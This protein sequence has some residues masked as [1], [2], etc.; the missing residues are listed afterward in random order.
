MGF[1]SRG[2]PDYTCLIFCKNSLIPRWGHVAN[3]E[4]LKMHNILKKEPKFLERLEIIQFYLYFCQLLLFFPWL[5]CWR[6]QHQQRANIR[7]SSDIHGFTWKA[8][9][10]WVTMVSPINEEVRS[11]CCE[12]NKTKLIHNSTW[13]IWLE[14]AK[15]VWG[16]KAGGSQ[17][18]EKKENQKGYEAEEDWKPSQQD[19]KKPSPLPGFPL[20]HRE[21]H[22]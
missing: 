22:H 17:E 19:R 10:L 1:F 2:A 6:C 15:A 18:E 20:Q 3:S 21:K 12:K 8:A 4:A 11:F 16:C 7:Y 13:L 9:E 5:K 14:I